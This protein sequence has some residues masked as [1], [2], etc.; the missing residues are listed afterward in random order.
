MP[1]TRTWTTRYGNVRN[2][3]RR[4]YSPPRR[5]TLPGAVARRIARQT[6]EQGAR[7]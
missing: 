5:R 1:K 7:P 6:K 3:R 2:P 4:R